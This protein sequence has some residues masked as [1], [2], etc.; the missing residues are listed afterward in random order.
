MEAPTPAIEGNVRQFFNEKGQEYF[1]AIVYGRRP[2]VRDS[3]RSHGTGISRKD[4]LD[5]AI[6]RWQEA[7][8]SLA[9]KSR[10]T[11]G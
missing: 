9:T 8:R 11:A 2:D 7:W 4:A 10:S 6:T 1:L 3:L 5:T